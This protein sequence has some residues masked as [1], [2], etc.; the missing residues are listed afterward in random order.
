MSRYV[1]KYLL[2]FNNNLTIEEKWE[3]Y[4]PLNFSSNCEYKCE[5]GENEDM[6]HIYQCELY[7]KEEDNNN[8]NLY[9]SI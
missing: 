4:I 8:N 7:C 5:C 2:P 3:I 6:N 9:F 1:S